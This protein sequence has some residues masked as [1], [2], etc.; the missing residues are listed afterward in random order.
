MVISRFIAA[1]QADERVVAAF[2]G[3]S[4]ATGRADTYSDLDLFL[5]TTDAAYADFFAGLPQSSS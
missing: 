4:Y 2:L 3:G 1:C 5:I